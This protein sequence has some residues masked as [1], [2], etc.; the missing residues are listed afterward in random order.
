MVIMSES[1]KISLMFGQGDGIHDKEEIF[2]E[3]ELKQLAKQVCKPC[4]EIKYKN[5][6][7]C[8]FCV[9]LLRFILG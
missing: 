6:T 3:N 8:S 4:W 5:R 9:V 7:N 2:E 1:L